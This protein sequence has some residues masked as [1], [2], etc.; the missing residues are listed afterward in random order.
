M[1]KVNERKL[2]KAEAIEY[3]GLGSG[4]KHGRKNICHQYCFYRMFYKNEKFLR[5]EV[6]GSM[7]TVKSG[8]FENL[9]SVSINCLTICSTR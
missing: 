5:Y 2:L 4:L 8:S 3:F 9:L 7:R 1:K 6:G